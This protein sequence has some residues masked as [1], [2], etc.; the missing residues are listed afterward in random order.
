[1][2]NLSII[3]P[4]YNEEQNLK[5]LYKRLREVLDNLSISWELIFI[6]DG[7]SDSTLKIIENFSSENA[8]VKALSLTRNF[9][10]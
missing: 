4:L 6:D 3:I 2:P 8:S 1:M 5:V 7:S 9:G 10:I